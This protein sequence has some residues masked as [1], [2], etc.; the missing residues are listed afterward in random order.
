M[1]LIMTFKIRLRFSQLSLANIPG[2]VL[3][4]LFFP[5]L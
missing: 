2:L 5:E 3:V 1:L 4:L